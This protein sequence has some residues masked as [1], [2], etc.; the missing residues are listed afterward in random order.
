MKLRSARAWTYDETKEHKVTLNL[1]HVRTIFYGTTTVKRLIFPL[2]P[3]K[4]TSTPAT[5]PNY[6]MA[7]NFL[8]EIA[9]KAFGTNEKGEY[10]ATAPAI[11]HDN[12]SG[13][14][15]PT[16]TTNKRSRTIPLGQTPFSWPDMN[17]KNENLLKTNQTNN[18]DQST[19]GRI[20][21]HPTN[22]Q[23]L[24]TPG[25]IAT[26]VGNLENTFLNRALNLKQSHALQT[27]TPK[28]TRS[29]KPTR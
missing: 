12:Y 29:R 9:L 8:T 13:D 18:Q 14:L 20:L 21:N 28:L 1:A 7:F 3:D 15:K 19:K 2:H 23:T 17:P 16:T 24:R 6:K 11:C 4:R 27:L 25:N 22:D 5:K 26:N 10:P